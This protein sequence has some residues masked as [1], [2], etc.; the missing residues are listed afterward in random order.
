FIY[1][2][3]LTYLKNDNHI[4]ILNA[5]T[6]KPVENAIVTLWN[7]YYNAQTNDYTLT[8]LGTYATDNTGHF[9]MKLPEK[10]NA[11]SLSF[12]IAAGNDRI[13]VTEDNVYYTLRQPGKILPDDE[14]EKQ[15]TNIHFFTDR[16]IY[17]P[18][19]DVFFKGILITRDPKTG[20]AKIIS[21]KTIRLYFRDP[22]NQ[23]TDSISVTSNAYGSIHGRFSIPEDRLN[24]IFRIT[25][26]GYHSS[27]FVSVEEYKRPK[28]QVSLTPE[29]KSYRFHDNVSVKGLV[30]GYAGNLL[31][32]T[33]VS[34]RVI[35]KPIFRPFP[36][37]LRRSY[38]PAY[39]GEVEITNGETTSSHDGTFEISFKAIPD[40]KP[41]KTG[42]KFLYEVIVH[43]TDISGEGGE[44]KAFVHAGYN[45]LEIQIDFPFEI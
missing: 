42:I 40:E 15:N 30:E 17:R 33:K 24:G 22:N 8:E 19:Q 29:K 14:Y 25:A 13:H 32:G 1:V 44:A 10:Q 41:G 5:V 6:G 7:R 12:E 21:N 4:Y 18:G 38:L 16:A 45:N 20:E 3:D 31:G 37:Y 35:R 39:S 26:E 28:Y 36:W 9:E 27:H 23:V 34:Y 43:T 2:S 11:L